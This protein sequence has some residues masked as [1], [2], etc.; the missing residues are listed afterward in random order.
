MSAK[1]IE[2]MV[3]MG[4]GGIAAGGDLVMDAF[5]SQ[6][7]AAGLEANVQKGCSAHKVGCRGLCAKDVLVDVI[8]DDNKA[9]YEYI[10]EDMVERLI[11]EHIKGGKPVEEWLVKEDYHNFHDK[12]VKVVLADCGN[13]DPESIDA[14][15]G[16]DGYKAQ[17]KVF[18]SLAPTETIEI[19]KESGLRGRGGAG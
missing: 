2:I 18:K 1:S 7:K 14:Y 5:Y 8:V 16:V 17:E 10:K 6:L 12:Q 3:C 19:I 4:T 15:I 11:E 9:T 13:I